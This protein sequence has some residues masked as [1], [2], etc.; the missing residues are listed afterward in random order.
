MNQDY[1]HKQNHPFDQHFQSVMLRTELQGMSTDIRGQ[2]T[3]VSN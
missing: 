2:K 3:D 1:Q